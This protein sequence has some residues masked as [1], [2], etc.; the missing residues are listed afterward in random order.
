MAAITAIYAHHVRHGLASFEEVPPDVEEM[1]RRF[2]DVRARR[3]PYFVAV[4]DEA[5]LGYAY[6]SPYRLRSAYR[7]TVEDS[8]Y[9]APDAFRKGIGRRLLTGLIE[10]CAAAGMRQMIAVIGDSGNDASVGLHSACGFRMTGTLQSVG[11]KFG[12]WVDGVI[13]QRTLGEGDHTLPA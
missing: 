6:A 8:V 4:E 10:T 9:L 11:F 1:T 7:Y 13:M 12:R 5:L 2:D 3:M